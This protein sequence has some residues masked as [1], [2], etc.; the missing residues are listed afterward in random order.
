ME[1]MR[2]D[3]GIQVLDIVKPAGFR[4]RI[5]VLTSL[6]PSNRVEKIRVL[7][8]DLSLRQL[9]KQDARVVENVGKTNRFNE[10]DIIGAPGDD[11]K[12][13]VHQISVRV[14]EGAPF[15]TARCRD[16]AD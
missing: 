5:V 1:T 11:A 16:G 8:P 9:H 15:R 6:W 14:E 10:H 12:H 2:G 13:A 7:A 3:D 4:S